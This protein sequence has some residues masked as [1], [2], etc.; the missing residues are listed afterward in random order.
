ME[1]IT[2][3]SVCKSFVI[4]EGTFSSHIQTYMNSIVNAKDEADLENFYKQLAQKKQPSVEQG[5]DTVGA[6]AIDVDG[7]VACATSTGGMP[8]KMIGRIGDSPL[9]G[10]GAYANKFG[11]CSS[12]GLSVDST[13]GIRS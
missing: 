8:G 10:C 6:V 1:L 4:E 7:H 2:N 13:F 5:H 12:T 9:F 3:D 11:A